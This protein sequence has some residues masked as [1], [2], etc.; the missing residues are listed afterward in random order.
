MIQEPWQQFREVH[1]LCLG[2]TLINEMAP[3]LNLL[4]EAVCGRY[5]VYL[6]IIVCSN[7]KVPDTSVIIYIYYIINARKARTCSILSI[8]NRVGRGGD[9]ASI[10]N[11]QP[12]PLE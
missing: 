3:A 4:R 7:Q 2:Q 10:P 6:S 9:D 8:W 11:F 12:C 5:I 1:V